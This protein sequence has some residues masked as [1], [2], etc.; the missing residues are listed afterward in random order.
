MK[1]VKELKHSWIT[2][3]QWQLLNKVEEMFLVFNSWSSFASCLVLGPFAGSE[4]SLLPF[5]EPLRI[6]SMKSLSV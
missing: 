5:R 2:F 3:V 4:P 6:P 1:F